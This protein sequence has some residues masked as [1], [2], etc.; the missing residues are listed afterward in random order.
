M[1]KLLMC[2]SHSWFKYCT[3]P[4]VAA[5]LRILAPRTE[6][7]PEND[8]LF[9]LLDFLS[10]LRRPNKDMFLGNKTFVVIEIIGE[11]GK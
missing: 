9:V 4:Q 8:D 11:G 3:T 5:N 1:N 7:A 10:A 6:Y 2:N